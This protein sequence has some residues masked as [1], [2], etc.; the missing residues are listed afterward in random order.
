M[1]KKVL[2]VVVTLLLFGVG[3]GWYVRHAERVELSKNP[4]R[5]LARN[6]HNSQPFTFSLQ[7]SHTFAVNQPQTIIFTIRDQNNRVFK[8]FDT[9][10]EEVLRLYVIRK[11]RT[12]FQLVH[13]GYDPQTGI[14]T[15]SNFSLPVD[16][17]YRLFV[18][19]T[20]NNAKKDEI[21]K[22]IASV[23]YTDITAGSLDRYFP[24]TP[25]AIKFFTSANGFDTNV[26]F[27]PGGD[28]PGTPTADYF[29]ANSLNTVAIEINKDGVPYTKLES[30]RGSVG[31]ITAFGPNLEFSNVNSDPIQNGQQSGLLTFNLPLAKPGQYVFFM[32]TQAGNQ[33]SIFDYDVAAKD[34]S[35]S[36][37]SS[38]VQQ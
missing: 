17:P 22:K 38:G 37:T 6:Q 26:F 9:S 20:T 34:L 29:F 8:S 4:L 36:P 21:G 2:I 13:A 16:G 31:R 10:D 24:A 28:S 33:T 15:A 11:D 14:F 32:Q 1:A 25:L 23:T 12:K 19:F 7:S 27:A 18:Q 3:G 5:P 35:V 30:Y